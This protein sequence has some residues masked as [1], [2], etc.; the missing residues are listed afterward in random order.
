MGGLKNLYDAGVGS[1]IKDSFEGS[2]YL[3]VLHSIFM[4]F[5]RVHV[6]KSINASF[7]TRVF[8]C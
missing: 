3:R 8:T 2:P 6:Q 5:L 4:Y 7:A 1:S